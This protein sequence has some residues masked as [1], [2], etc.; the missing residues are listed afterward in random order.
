MLHMNLSGQVGPPPQRTN[1]TLAFT[2]IET[3]TRERAKQG[4]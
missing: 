3:I 2:E 4:F 1:I